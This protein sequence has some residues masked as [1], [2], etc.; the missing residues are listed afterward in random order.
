YTPTDAALIP[1]GEIAPVTGTGMD[2]TTPR[3]VGDP[4]KK[5][6]AVAG[7]FDCNFVIR[8]GG[9]G[10]ALAARVRECKS[11]RTMETWTTQPGL[12]FY[13]ANHFDG[14]RGRGGTRH[15]RFAAMCFETQHFPDSVN[16][17]RFPA[18]I[19]RPGQVYR[20]TCMYKFP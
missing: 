20:Q 13:T 14:I 15:G 19:L 1:T 2:F 9:T 5:Y 11:G 18:V 12:Q 4:M 8:N 3:L 17:P 6:P 7:G 10:L 16:K